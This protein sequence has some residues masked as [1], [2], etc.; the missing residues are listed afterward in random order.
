MS[1]IA[2]CFLFFCCVCE[3]REIDEREKS[4][5]KIS[6]YEKLTLQIIFPRRQ[7]G[8]KIKAKFQYNTPGLS[9]TINLVVVSCT[10]SFTKRMNAN[11]VL[12]I[13]AEVRRNV[14]VFLYFEISAEKHKYLIGFAAYFDQFYD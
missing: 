4:Q 5:R 1:Y 11:F 13:A 6:F 3:T 9:I 7:K 10:S 12:W 14:S 2:I 8:K